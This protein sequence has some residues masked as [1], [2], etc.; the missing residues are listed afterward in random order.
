MEIFNL[1]NDIKVVYV[2][3][4]SFPNGIMAAHQKLHSLVPDI[5]HRRVFG[6]SRP[7]GA[8]II[9]K[10]AAELKEGDRFYHSDLQ[11]FTIKKGEYLAELI[12]NFMND[13]PQIG[14]TFQKL[15]RQPD[16]DPEGYCLEEYINEKDVRCMVGIK[17]GQ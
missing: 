8:G 2:H 12:T 14:N 4:N 13:V 17:R 3:T 6:I 11:I 9:Y 10:A 7:D 5:K 16:I 15:I 1:A